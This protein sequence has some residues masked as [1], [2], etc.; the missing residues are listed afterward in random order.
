MPEGKQTLREFYAEKGPK[1]LQEQVTVVLYYLTRIIE[2]DG[3]GANHIY[4]ALKDVS[5]PIPPDIGHTARLTS[6]R[7]GWIDSSKSDDL[8]IAIGGENFIE[9]ELPRKQDK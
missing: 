1:T 7:K 6:N 3:I 9:H 2:R 8:K 5:V 4:T